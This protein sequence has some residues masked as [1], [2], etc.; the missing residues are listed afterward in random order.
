MDIP[1]LTKEQHYL[2]RH[3]LSASSRE[4]MEKMYACTLF[5]AP[6]QIFILRGLLGGPSVTG[7]V[8]AHKL[9]QHCFAVWKNRIQ[10]NGE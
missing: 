7:L 8:N 4:I 3:N 2:L 6:E 9:N 10:T 1:T 5:S